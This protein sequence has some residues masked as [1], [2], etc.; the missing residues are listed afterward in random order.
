MAKDLDKDFQRIWLETSVSRTY[1]DQDRSDTEEE[2]QVRTTIAQPTAN[3]STQRQRND[4]LKVHYSF[5]QEA[6]IEAYAWAVVWGGQRQVN[7][8]VVR[9]FCLCFDYSGIKQGREAGGFGFGDDLMKITGHSIN[10]FCIV[11]H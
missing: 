9:S 1:I 10:L 4:M 7:G 2:Y 3:S 6:L 8:E 11:L 5:L